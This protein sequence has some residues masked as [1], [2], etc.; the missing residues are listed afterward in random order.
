MD[1]RVVAVKR[2]DDR[3]PGVISDLVLTPG[4]RFYLDTAS[5]YLPD[6]ER[7][8]THFQKVEV[9]KDGVVKEFVVDVIVTASSDL[10]NRTITGAGL[11]GIPGLYAISLQRPDGTVI[12]AHDHEVVIQA[13]RILY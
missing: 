5:S 9:V 1:A 8:T 6:D 13:R 12:D 10:V 7:L 2:R 11:R 3:E 4:D